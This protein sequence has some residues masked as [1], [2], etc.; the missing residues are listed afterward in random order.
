MLECST[1]QIDLAPSLKP[2][3]GLLINLTPDH[4]DRHGTMENYAAIKQRLL[5]QVPSVGQV[6]VGK[7]D[8]ESIRVMTAFCWRR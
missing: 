8:R 1:F 4:L 6:I 7:R 3:V 5:Q 2:S